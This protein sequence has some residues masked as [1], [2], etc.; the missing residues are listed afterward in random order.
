MHEY[1]SERELGKKEL[2]AEK[3]TVSVF[4]GI[5]S[6]Y[7]KY[8]KNFSYDFPDICPDNDMVCGTNVQLLNATIKA[9]IPD[10]KTPIEIKWREY[11][12]D[13]VD[14]YS[15]LDLIEFC[16]SRIADINEGDYHDWF[17]HFHIF[18]PETQNE[19]E[20]FREEVNQI[21]GRNGLAFYL[22]KDGMIKRQLPTQL[23]SLLQNLNIR[24]KDDILNELLNSAIDNIRKPKEFERQI[25]LEK[26]WDA[27]ERIKTF[28]DD[29]PKKKKVS[30]QKLISNIA[31]GTP[32]FDV[33]L[34]SE[35]K[36]LTDIGNEFQIRHF[37]TSKIKINSMKQVDYLFYRMIS[38]I[39]LCI[40]KVNNE[41]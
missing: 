22:D 12:E 36:A 41:I 6:L 16:Y 27:F 14:K 2:K 5:V 18:F 25:A 19:K 33:I 13:E 30:A 39:D 17:K 35:F 10:L 34:E 37:E 7:K 1:F 8:Q 21:L 28:Y 9:Q 20:N 3:V 26:I 32:K 11:D 24:T 31:E 40:D 23:D 29:N 15:L 4:N 38:L